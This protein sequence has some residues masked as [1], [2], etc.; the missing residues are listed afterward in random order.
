ME[1]NDKWV[2]GEIVRKWWGISERTLATIVYDNGIQAYDVNNELL[3]VDE[4]SGYFSDGLKF[5]LDDIE[6]FELQNEH[7]LKNKNTENQII[8]AQS[9]TEDELGKRLTAKEVAEKINVD[10]KTVRDNYHELGGMRLGRQY[11]F[12]ER[13]V[14]DAIQK[15]TE[16]DWPSAEGW[17]E[18]GKGISDEE[19]SV[20]MGSQ[21]EAK[22]RRRVEREDR[23]NLFG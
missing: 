22:T 19:G 13:S 1:K 5:K 10:V 6:E 7:L 4:A 3:D 11:V 15:R 18:T 21:K 2:Y 14:I 20:D 12:F 9:N 16:M 17:K 23:H 8:E